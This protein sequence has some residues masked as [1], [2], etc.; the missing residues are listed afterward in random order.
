MNNYKVIDLEYS[1][2]DYYEIIHNIV[3]KKREKDEQ[4]ED[5]NDKR[6]KVEKC[7]M[8]IVDFLCKKTQSI[9]LKSTGLIK[10]LTRRV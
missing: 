3:I 7:L 8:N 4:T 1:F 10:V 2:E 9:N 6:A 5:L